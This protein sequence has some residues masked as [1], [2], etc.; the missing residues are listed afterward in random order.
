LNFPAGHTA[1]TASADRSPANGRNP[2]TDALVIAGQ[3]FFVD[4]EEISFRLL[5]HIFASS[6]SRCEQKGFSNRW[7]VPAPRGKLVARPLCTP[8]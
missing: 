3:R 1:G 4:Y 8:E 5:A 2:V 6:I 7:R